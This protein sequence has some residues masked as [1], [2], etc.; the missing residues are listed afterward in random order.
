ME[1]FAHALGGATDA[2]TSLLSIILGPRWWDTYSE[3]AE[4]RRQKLCPTVPLKGGRLTEMV[5]R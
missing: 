3:N 5:A 2:S 4:N 1:R